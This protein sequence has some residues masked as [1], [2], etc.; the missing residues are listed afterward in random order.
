MSAAQQSASS[1]SFPIFRSR[2][3]ITSNGVK[4]FLQAVTPQEQSSQTVRNVQ[5]A[6]VYRAK[7][8]KGKLFAD[9]AWDLLLELY[10]AALDQRRISIT[11]LCMGSG[12]SLTTG[13]RWITVFEK[14][15]LIK[16]R[17][18]PVDARR[19]YVGLSLDGFT[20]MSSFFGTVPR[21]LPGL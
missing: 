20:A 15:G 7:L 21:E 12:V 9:P 19:V 6:R 11:R 16:K 18:D 13:L 8:F 14:Q 1:H 4:A 2:S 10:A 5:R 3:D 17:D